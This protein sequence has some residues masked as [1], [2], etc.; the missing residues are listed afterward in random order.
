MLRAGISLLLSLITLLLIGPADIVFY[1][2]FQIVQYGESY[3]TFAHP[4]AVL[5]VTFLACFVG[6]FMFIKTLF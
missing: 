4:F 3:N 1:V 5:S 2:S 6:W